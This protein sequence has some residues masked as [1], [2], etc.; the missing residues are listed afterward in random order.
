MRFAT[1]AVALFLATNVVVAD[2]N[3][4]TYLINFDLIIS[5]AESDEVFASLQL[6]GI[7]LQADKPFHGRDV[8]GFD[9]FFTVSEQDDGKERLT[10]ELYQYET[11]RKKAIKSELVSEVE[12]AFRSPNRFEANNESTAR[13]C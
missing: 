12:L 1:A 11:R 5:N 2:E 13:N 6:Q 4:N 7:R 9:Y 10:I 8:A 3:S